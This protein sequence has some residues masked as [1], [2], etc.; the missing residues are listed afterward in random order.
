MGGEKDGDPYVVEYWPSG[1]GDRW[2]VTEVTVEDGT[3]TIA[4]VAGTDEAPP[5]PAANDNSGGDPPS[6]A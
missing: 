4:P 3:V 6:A 1:D 5:E 2:G